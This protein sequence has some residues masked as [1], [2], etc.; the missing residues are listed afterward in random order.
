MNFMS[1]DII[2]MISDFLES[3]FVSF[4]KDF[5]SIIPKIAYFIVA[6][7]LS[8]VDLFQVLFRKIAGMDPIVV[9]GE[10]VTGDSA[11]NIILDAIFTGKYPAIS[12]VFWSLT[13]LGVF[14][15]IITSIVATLRLE[16]TPD[17][18]TKN[19][20][21]KS[22]IIGFVKAIFTFAIV[23]VTCFF[24]MWFTNV[25]IQ[26]VSTITTTQNSRVEES[27]SYY[28]KW[29]GVSGTSSDIVLTDQKASYTAYDVF[30]ISIP[31]TAQPFS[32]LMFKA[33][34]YSANRLR[35]EGN[36][37]LETYNDSSFSM[38][39]FDGKLSDA[40]V[41]A[42]IIDTG[43]AINAKMKN[44]GGTLDYTPEIKEYYKRGL[45]LGFGKIDNVT[46]F[47]KYNV[48]LVWY[49]YDL[50]QFNYIVGFAAVIMIGKM[51]FKF[52]LALMARLFEVAGLFLVSP[53]PIG[54]MPLDGG[55]AFGRW[56]GHFVAKVGLLLV[57]VFGI[58][59]VSPIITLIQDIKMFNVPLLDNIVLAM[60]LVAALNAVEA[61]NNT[62][63]VILFNKDYDSYG[64]A[65]S[66]AETAKGH[67][68]SGLNATKTAFTLG[69][70]PVMAAGRAT[71]TL[72]VAGGRAV[73]RNAPR[74]AANAR[75]GLANRLER[76][77]I[78]RE[79][80]FDS[81]N[82]F[83]GMDRGRKEEM[84][85]AFLKTDEGKGFMKDYYDR[86]GL[87]G[88][89]SSSM[90]RNA[91]L[92][93]TATSEE[94]EMFHKYGTDTLRAE[95]DR[96]MFAKTAEAGKYEA[97][98]AEYEAA[99]NTYQ[100]LSDGRKASY[101]MGEGSTPLTERQQ[102]IR[103]GRFY[104]GSALDQ[105]VNAAKERFDNTK[106]G[107]K[108][109]AAGQKI[110]QFGHNVA[111]SKPGR[112]VKNSAAP[113][114]SAKA[115]SLGRGIARAGVG[116]ADYLGSKTTQDNIKETRNQAYGLMGIIPGSEFF[117]KPK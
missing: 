77:E 113:W 90:A 30:G 40:A 116:V 65:M 62:V 107:Q 101:F 47:S 117:R 50:W 23:P 46:H 85:D 88:T 6:C 25:L 22:I 5:L 29:V 97:G 34:A 53:I 43:F 44:G 21:K 20:S 13:I 93:G 3:G 83:A 63:S 74:W 112:W 19:N 82:A 2:S 59:I 26:T 94:M 7:M 81:N 38:G 1:L 70:K 10:T 15:L 71:G 73:V 36:G 106:F 41:A 91:L 42:D 33:S 68:Q 18:D 67:I 4:L 14:M 109:S 104:A 100:G 39:I 76:G 56:R 114:V 111:D 64:K 69:A 80:A 37:L 28:D 66:A 99:F 45:N 24:G 102:N 60:F 58:N 57:M 103:D 95:H 96:N 52:C 9:S 92:N 105:R 12:T 75:Q 32:G 110:S 11:T 79:I 35:L 87:S 49:F 8:L 48:E 108:M 51:Y 55:G 84:V 89:T 72:A 78:R 31:T 27:M 54:M 98:S 17:K 115:K 61:I 16:Y 86:Q